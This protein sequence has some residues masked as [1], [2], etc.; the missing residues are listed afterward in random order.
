MGIGVITALF[1]ADLWSLPLYTIGG[2]SSSSSS[3]GGG[4]VTIVITVKAVS[5][6]IGT[7]LTLWV[8]VS[9]IFRVLYTHSSG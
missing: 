3:S 5:M 8:S 4:D 6:T 2:S 1:G 7:L 9:S